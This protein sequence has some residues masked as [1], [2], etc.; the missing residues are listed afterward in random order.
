MN[1]FTNF[2]SSHWPWASKLP[3]H[4]ISREQCELHI[5]CSWMWCW[6]SGT[7]PSDY[8]TIQRSTL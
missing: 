8:I 7:S 3:T 2:D 5:Y 6:I 4:K 1:N